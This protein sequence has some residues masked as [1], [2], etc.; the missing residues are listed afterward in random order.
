M[1]A[2]HPLTNAVVS[3]LASLEYNGGGTIPVKPAASAET[4]NNTITARVS[5]VDTQAYLTD[6][7]RLEAV[8]V[9]VGYGGSTE[10]QETLDKVLARFA[11]WR[12]DGTISLQI[13]GTDTIAPIVGDKVVQGWIMTLSVQRLGPA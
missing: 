1:V 13:T 4:I 3:R 9:I 10:V 7:Q 6:G 12:P 5:G 11:D 8:S 2:A